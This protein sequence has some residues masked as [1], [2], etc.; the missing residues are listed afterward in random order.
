MTYEEILSY[1]DKFNVLSEKTKDSI[2]TIAFHV[3]KGGTGKTLHSYEFAGFCADVLKKRVLVIDGDR[4]CN[5][6]KT[7][8]VNGELT[9]TEVFKPDGK[10]PIYHTNNPNIDII[11]GDPKFTDEGANANEW[12]TK[13]LEFYYW[14]GDNYEYLNS[15]Y[16]V[17]VT[18]THNDT[19]K[20]TY[21]LLVGADVV[22]N[23]LKPDQNSFDALQE[24]S[25]KIDEILPLTKV[26]NGRQ[27]TYGY[28]AKRLVLITDVRYFGNNP[29]TE[30]T[31]FIEEVSQVDGYIGIIP[32]NKLF[33]SS[34]LD[35]KNIFELYREMSKA[36]Q[37]KRESFMRHL[38]EVYLN[39]YYE[40]CKK[41]YEKIS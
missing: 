3:D 6:T 31:Q 30:V 32:N 34:T 15:M 20:C 21:N 14:M 16:D 11:V 12:A 8:N 5:L 26:R 41:C 17:I 25:D 18:D 39:I 10:M 40:A 28:D 13:Y 35:N 27:F 29:A 38:Q 2:K 22:V 9:I 4:S 24:Y 37:A 33:L 23:V 19:S 36:E 7:F 1:A